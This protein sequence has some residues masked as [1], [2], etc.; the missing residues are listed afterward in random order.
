MKIAHLILVHNN[1]DQLLRLVDRLHHPQAYIFV[2]VDAKADLS[3]FSLIRDIERVNFIKNRVAC[4]WAGFSLVQAELNGF[5]E[6]LNFGVEFDYVNLLSGSDYP[7]KSANFVHEFLSRNPGKI[8][9]RFEKVGEQWK[10]QEWRTEKYYLDEFRVAEKL[11]PGRRFLQKVL[12]VILPKR[13]PP[14]EVYGRSQWFTIAPLYLRF[15]FERI[16]DDRRLLAFFKYTWAPDEFFFQ[17]ILYNSDFRIYMVNDNLR[18][19][20]MTNNGMGEHPETITLKDKD[21][22]E[23]SSKLFARKFDANFSEGIL[24]LIDSMYHGK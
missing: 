20:Q 19:I 12:N 15:V 24:Q 21:R 11:L 1:P 14:V 8:F 9:M 22:I 3:S 17:T 16:R 6:I 10:E 4:R 5:E 7:I 18:L 13:K 2:H 23:S